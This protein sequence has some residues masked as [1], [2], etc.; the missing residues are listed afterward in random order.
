MTTATALSRGARRAGVALASMLGLLALVDGAF[1]QSWPTRPVTVIIPFTAGNAN[2]IIGRIIF[3]QLSRQIGHPFVI[4]NRG[5]AGGITAVNSVAKAAPDGY[6]VLLH[7]TSFSSAYSLHK[8]LPYDT[9]NDFAAVAPVGNQPT[10]LVTAPSK[11]YKT[12]AE[13]IAAAKAKPGALNFASAGIGSASHLAAERFNASAGIKAQHV[14]FRGPQEAFAEVLSG[15]LDYYFLPVAPALSLIK[16]G[17][18]LALAVGTEKR[19]VALPDVP[20]TA[21]AGLKDSGYVFWTGIF[22]PAKTPKDIIDK[23]YQETQKA[24]QV[25]EVQE[26][27]AKIGAEPMPMSQP[28]FEKYFKNDVLETA[29]LLKQAGVSP[30]N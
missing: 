16:E 19:A 9:L 4:E 8:N 27:I 12:V 23:L 1:A 7:S 6:T 10:V 24:L 11:G 14:P 25:P 26:K 5:G 21:E 18:L 3:D 22:L 13:L 29:K 20:T 30:A 2:D 15:R 28:D 17:K